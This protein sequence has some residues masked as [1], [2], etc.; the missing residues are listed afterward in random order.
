MHFYK[1]APF[2]FIFVVET[3][4]HARCAQLRANGSQATQIG[5]EDLIII[6]EAITNTA[7][8]IV[9]LFSPSVS[10]KL[11]WPKNSSLSPGPWRVASKFI[12]N[13]VASELPL[14]PVKSTAAY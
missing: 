7:P 13:P 1:V 3:E 2:Q 14:L 9:A 5:I 4:V 8:G 10:S 12:P 11:A 6:F